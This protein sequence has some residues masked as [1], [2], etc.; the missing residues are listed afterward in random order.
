MTLVTRKVK[1]NKPAGK[2]ARSGADYA[3][4]HYMTALVSPW[5]MGAIG[6]RIPSRFAVPTDTK[7]FNGRVTLGSDASGS[8]SYVYIGH[9]LWTAFAPVPTNVLS[10]PFVLYGSNPSVSA[11]TSLAGLAGQF[12]S[13][14]VVANGCRIRSMLAPLSATGRLVAARIPMGKRFVGPNALAGYAST[15]PNLMQRLTGM[16]LESLTNHVP[17]SIM[18]LNVRQ[19]CTAGEL[20]MKHMSCANRCIGE[21]AFE[22]RNASSTD[23]AYNATQNIG[24]EVIVNIT[25]GA[26]VASDAEDDCLTDGWTCILIRGEGFPA[27]TACLDIEVSSHLEGIPIVQTTG[28]GVAAY[29][30]S[31]ASEPSSATTVDKVLNAIKNVPFGQLSD[32]AATVGNAY[33]SYNQNRMMG[34]AALMLGGY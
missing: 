6:A 13:Y 15:V 18:N 33:S 19:E 10:N 16:S 25:G 29:V 21:T 1:V 28:I 9:P 30:S 26:T 34:R 5:A 11:I 31:S 3:A 17:I 32:I 27:S 7:H 20:M 4:S 14:R 8:F 23:T 12:S 2:P 24:D 22:F